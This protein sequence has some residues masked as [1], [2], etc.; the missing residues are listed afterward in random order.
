MSAAEKFF[1]EC[2]VNGWLADGI[3]GDDKKKKFIEEFEKLVVEEIEE[4][5]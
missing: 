2:W 5:K 1:H 3:W 4:S